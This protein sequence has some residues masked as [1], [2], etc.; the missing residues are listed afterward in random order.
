VDLSGLWKR[1]GG[2][3]PFTKGFLPPQIP[4]IFFGSF[5]MVPC[6]FTLLPSPP[7]VQNTRRPVSCNLRIDGAAHYYTTQNNDSIPPWPLSNKSISGQRTRIKL[8]IKFSVTT[9]ID[10]IMFPH[11]VSFPIL[12]SGFQ[13]LFWLEI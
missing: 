7:S 12:R 5:M 1:G 2:G 10:P 11:Q 9:H 6:L 13:T 3:K 8:R 4:K